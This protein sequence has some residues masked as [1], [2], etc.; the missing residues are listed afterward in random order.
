MAD[1]PIDA[2][3]MIAA[4]R[5]IARPSPATKRRIARVIDAPVRAPR[6]RYVV[7]AVAAAAALVASLGWP[8]SWL[9][10]VPQEEIRPEAPYGEATPPQ[11][12]RVESTHRP[13]AIAGSAVHDAKADVPRVVP[14]D[15]GEREPS[16]R[17]DASSKS[18]ERAHVGEHVS[19]PP[20]NGD[21]LL[22]EM[23]LLER[24]RS[25]L[26]DGRPREALALVEEHART[27]PGGA[28]VEERDA[29][30]VIASC[31]LA[32]RGES[33]LAARLAFA[34]DYPRSTY[35]A[36]VRRACADE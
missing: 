32:D 27:F 3:E 28:L 11:L 30:R 19:S 7:I 21:A 16:A 6:W 4:Y 23:A 9:D 29:L 35:A 5:A 36:R 14:I 18:R 2:R 25:R 15:A 10:R 26:A 17:R 12:G 20:S 1:D 13:R 34:R 24:A 33:V 8:G 22:A 31:G